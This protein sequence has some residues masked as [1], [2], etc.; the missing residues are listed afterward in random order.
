MSKTNMKN[1]KT[2]LKT[3]RFTESLADSLEKEA[4]EEDTTVNSLANAI[5]Y[6]DLEW[7]KKAAEFGF[8]WIH[9]SEYRRLVDIADDIEL[10]RLGREVIFPTWKEMA[11]FWLQD[12]TPEGIL[13]ALSLRSKFGSGPRTRITREND[14]VTIVIRHEFGPK[15]SIILKS[16][17]QELAKAFHAMPRLNVGE[18]VITARFKVK[19]GDATNRV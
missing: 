6:G 2:R 10:E 11:E 3:F 7:D 17:L 9:R 12:S 1:R 4:A 13:E 18:S 16:A 8:I 5:L 15:R 14:E 19:G